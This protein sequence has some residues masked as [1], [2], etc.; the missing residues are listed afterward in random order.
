MWK[1]PPSPPP[2]CAQ[3][4]LR[5]GLMKARK[6]PTEMHPYGYARDRFIWSLISA[7]GIFFLGAGERARLCG[8]RGWRGVCVCGGG[9]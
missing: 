5:I 2:L 6:G 9:G 8:G 4:L 1:Q 3:M 7:V